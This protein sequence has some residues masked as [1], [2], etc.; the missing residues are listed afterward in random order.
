MRQRLEQGSSEL[1]QAYMRLFLYKVEVCQDEI[2]LA[3]P[4]AVLAKAALKD[5]SSSVSEVLSYARQW[6]ARKDSNL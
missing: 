5:T 3:G 4:K 6:R 1:K 2:R